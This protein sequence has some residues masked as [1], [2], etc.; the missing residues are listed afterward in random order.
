MMLC[1]GII[2]GN[3]ARMSGTGAIGLVFFC[4]LISIA[5][6]IITG[7]L[8][9]KILVPAMI[10]TIGTLLVWEAIPRLI[11]QEGVRIPT[12]M[13]AFAREPQVYVVFI[14]AFVLFF[15]LFN[16]TAFGH[17]IRAVGNNQAIAV[18][19]GLNI[20]EIKL[21]SFV[22]GS[23]FLGIAAF[24]Y[25]SSAANVRNV[26]ALGSMSLMMDGFMG[27]FMAM[28][29]ARYCNMSLAVVIGTFSMRMLTNGFVA[30]GFSSTARDVVQGF[31]LLALLTIS[32]NAG[33][34]EKRKADKA[35][36]M[37]ANLE[38]NKEQC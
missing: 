17:N 1:A 19:A 24:M 18:K 34:F 9:N 11:F 35:Y 29:I 27:M 2:G 15:L 25:I 8:Y 37:E 20:D 16:K 22:S 14:I 10:L 33:L 5:L 38:S 3:L 4:M 28:F 32:A 7:I 21:M 26:T 13:A 23:V 12:P 31:F 6:G 30:M 36:A